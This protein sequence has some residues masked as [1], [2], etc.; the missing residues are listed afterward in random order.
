MKRT[1]LSIVI[2]LRTTAALLAQSP[3]EQI[4][5]EYML[6]LP[7][8][9]SWNIEFASTY[10]TVLEQPK[11][12]SL[13]VQ[14]TPEYS[15]SNHIDLM[16][17]VFAGR[18]FQEATVTTSEIREMLGARIHFTPNKRVLTRFLIRFEQRNQ[19][20]RETHTWQHSTRT[21]LR[22]ET[23]T[24]INKRSMQAGDK[25]WYAIV[26]GEFFIVMD[27]DVQERFANRF[28][29][30]TGI[31]YRLNYSVRFELMYTLQMSRNTLDNG[32]ETTDNIFRIRVKH[33]L[34]KSKPSQTDGI[35][36]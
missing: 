12:R 28:R 34:N 11:W 33:F 7:F 1:I 36:N 19:L 9:N 31:G 4:W 6:N 26:D 8:A 18:T 17:A 15:V 10:S 21:R 32:Y 13:D 29:L 5:A 3:S 20:E 22:A 14:I 24:P 30:R 2:L 25:L 16:G 27:Q 23:L 35:S